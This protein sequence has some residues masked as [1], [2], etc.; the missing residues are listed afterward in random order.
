MRPSKLAS[1]NRSTFI[2]TSSPNPDRCKKGNS[3]ADRE[4]TERGQREDRED[5][6]DRENRERT[7]RGQRE[8]RERTKSTQGREK[9]D[10][11]GHQYVGLCHV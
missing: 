7:A 11:E 8:D 9:R 4:R 3:C 5:R 10:I 1:A 2:K 6:E